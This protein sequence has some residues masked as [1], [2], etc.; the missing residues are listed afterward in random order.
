MSDVTNN[1]GII[2]LSIVFSGYNDHLKKDNDYVI[3]TTN[4]DRHSHG[5][6]GK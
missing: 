2:I 4:F 5:I 3:I 1:I 6:Y